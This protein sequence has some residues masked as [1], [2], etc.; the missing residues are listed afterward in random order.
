[1]SERSVEQHLYDEPF[2][3]DF[4]QAVRLLE[5]LSPGRVHV[6]HGGPPRREVVR[7]RALP[8]LEFPASA[9]HALA[10]AAGEQAPPLMTVTFLGLHG[11]SGVLPRHYNE[12]IQRLDRERRRHHRCARRRSAAPAPAL[13][14]PLVR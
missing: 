9:V 14:G 1:M 2:V 4:F 12:L 7:F 10:P 11:P 6:G 5:R 3:F 8:S 13:Y